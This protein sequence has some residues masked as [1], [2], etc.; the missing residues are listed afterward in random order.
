MF[1]G[2]QSDYSA[3]F[4]GMNESL[5]TFFVFGEAEIWLGLNSALIINTDLGA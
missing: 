2:V 5:L 3:G 1:E 4:P